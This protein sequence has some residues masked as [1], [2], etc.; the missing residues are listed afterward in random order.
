MKANEEITYQERLEMLRETKLSDTKEKWEEIGSIDFDDSGLVL[1][2]PESRDVIESVTVFGQPATAIVLKG[3]RIKSNHPSG[4]FFGPKACGEN[5][6]AL[7]ERHPVHVDPISSLA[8][9]YMVKFLSYRNPGWNPDCDYSHLHER[10]EKYK[11]TMNSGIGLPQHFCQDMTIG[12][13]I[14]WGGILKRIRRY[15]EINAPHAGDF[16]DGLEDIVLG[17][18]DWI[19]RNARE[20]GRM[21]E[22]EGD[23][24]LRENLR[25]VSR[26]NEKIATEPPATFHE[27]CQWILWY[28][29]IGHM[30]NNSGSLGC[31]DRLLLPYYQRDTAAGILSDEEAIFHLAC[32]LQRDVSY[33]H[34]GGPDETGKD[35]TNPVSFLVLEAAHR[36]KIPANIGVC[37]GKGVDR[38]LLRKSVEMLIEDK[39]GVPKFLGID[40]VNDGFTRNGYSVELARQRIYC[41]CH[42]FAL[43]GREYTLNDCVRINLLAVFDVALREMVAE[44]EDRSSV[45][46]LWRRFEED[47]REAVLVIAEGLDFHLEHMHEVFPELVLDLLC[48]GPIEK[49]LDASHGGV[50][51][52]NMGVDGSALAN[53][54]DSFAALEHHI[55]NEKDLTWKELMRHLDADWAGARGERARLMM[56]SVPRY[57]S[58]NSCADACAVRISTLFAGLIKEKPTPAGRSMVPG[59]FSWA[60]T[61]PLGKD[62]GATPD[63][64]HAGDRVSHGAN[65]SPGFRKDA[66]PT[67]LAVAVGSVQPGYGNTAPMQIDMDPGLFKDEEDIDTV[68]ALIETHFSLGGTM[69]NMNIIDKKEIL[70]AHEDPATHADLI[71]RVT[72]F[73]A[74]F[75]SLSREFRQFVVDR[76]L[77]EA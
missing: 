14:G 20:A 28:Q 33:T 37:V 53:V 71:V 74:Y 12:L 8:G 55:E 2:P 15:R 18:Q 51:F 43:P 9:A 57:G 1:P 3:V 68:V 50:E 34:L 10:Q 49:G 52:Y 40:S 31:L 6:R 17:L 42:W 70:E 64:R 46:E 11:L 59:L 22:E 63:G 65:P 7:L 67:A 54:A 16:Y 24:T 76:I 44:L 58:G 66:A 23:P 35:A 4:G 21:Q 26:I 60:L 5:F 47:L 19:C 13:E 62:V 77:A 41:G 27:A 38:E 29:L 39:N 56:R 32:L 30:Y 45:D 72:G 73:S 25:N 69:I 61:I 36:L 48:H 75:A